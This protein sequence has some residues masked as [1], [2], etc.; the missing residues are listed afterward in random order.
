V[1]GDEA[2]ALSLLDEAFISCQERCLDC[3]P[4]EHTAVEALCEAERKQLGAS[5]A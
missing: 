4:M 1:L 3:Q 2:D 5:L